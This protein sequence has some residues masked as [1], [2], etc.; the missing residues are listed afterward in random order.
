MFGFWVVFD[1]D[2]GV[3]VFLICLG[4]S[5]VFVEYGVD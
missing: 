2:S 5:G 1:I 4:E 3:V